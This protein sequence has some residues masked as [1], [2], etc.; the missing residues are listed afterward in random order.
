M[1]IDQ[2]AMFGSDEPPLRRLV[3]SQT[4]RLSRQNPVKDIISSTGN[5]RNAGMADNSNRGTNASPTSSVPL[6][7][8]TEFPPTSSTIAQQ[9]LTLPTPRTSSFDNV[10]R[11]ATTQAHRVLSDQVSPIRLA[12]H[13]AVVAIAAA[14]LLVSSMEM[15]DWNLTLPRAFPT[16]IADST[17][18]SAADAV[19]QA[20]QI[21]GSQANTSVLSGSSLQKAIV[22]FTVIPE[23]PQ[24]GIRTYSV[25]SG[26]T[27]LGIAD[28]FGLKPESI[29][30]ANASLELNP[31]ILR[32]GDRLEIPPVDGVLHTV[33]VGDTL[34]SIA[35][36]YKVDI[37]TITGYT[38]NELSDASAALS[39]GARLVVPGGVK[40]YVA[41]QVY[42]HSGPIPSTATVGSG[43][44]VWPTSGS[45]TQRYWSGHKGIDIGSWTGA[46]V[47]ASDNGHVIVAQPGW[48]NGYG[49]MV[50]IDHGNGFVSLYGH[51]NSIWVRK[52]E[53]ISRGQQVGTV[54]NTGNSTGPHLHME[55]RYLGVPRNPFSYLQ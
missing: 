32:I 8:S 15:P 26:D 39:I 37:A 49:N 4:S 44:F 21:F 6:A 23:E 55:I 46:P 22:P 53:N 41:P 5:R 34:S 29:Q 40:P 33:Q 18:L 50:V 10:V 3:Q 19:G 2:N 36:K 11:S 24:E 30:W 48:N 28:K 7:T 47:N 9:S 12:G 35:A 52:G 45:V 42:A 27:V 51:L 1:S 31:D 20:S 16:N 25:T 13:L 38:Q 54:G 17:T 43:S 14:V